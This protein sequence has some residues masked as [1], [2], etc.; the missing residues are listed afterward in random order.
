[1]ALGSCTL[2]IYGN[3]DDDGSAPSG[4]FGAGASLYANLLASEPLNKYALVHYYLHAGGM[5]HGLWHYGGFG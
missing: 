1:M 3:A 2:G 5:W 4:Q